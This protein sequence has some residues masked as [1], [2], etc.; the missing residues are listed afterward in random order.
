M[1]VVL[2]DVS[3]K[4]RVESLRRY[5]PPAL[6]DQ[7]CGL[8]VAHMQRRRMSGCLPMCAVLPR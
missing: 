8:D 1:A 7:V 4:K 2:D 5:L 6:V 3:E